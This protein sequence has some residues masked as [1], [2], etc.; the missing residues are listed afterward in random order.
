MKPVTMSVTFTIKE[1]EAMLSNA[2]AGGSVEVI[3]T[4]NREL[5]LR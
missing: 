5:I 2:K 4:L 1:L 3:L